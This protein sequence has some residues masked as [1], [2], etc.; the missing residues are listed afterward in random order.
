MLQWSELKPKIVVS[1]E[2]TIENVG[3]SNSFLNWEIVDIPDWGNWTFTHSEGYNLTPEGGIRTVDVLVIAPE[4][5]NQNFTGE[6]K[7]VNM[8]N[9]SDYETIAVS[10]STLKN[11]VI[12]SPFIQFLENYPRLFP[13]LRNILKL[14]I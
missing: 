7:I 14:S 3:D 1:G 13:I 10:L 12:S 11:K 6:I 8:E 5:K 4:E 9:A 2:F